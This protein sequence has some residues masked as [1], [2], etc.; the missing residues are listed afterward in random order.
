MRRS[1]KVE[2][3]VPR[4]VFVFIPCGLIVAEA[5][6][7]DASAWLMK[8]YTS[9]RNE[10]VLRSLGFQSLVSDA[11]QLLKPGPRNS[12]PLRMLPRLPWTSWPPT[13]AGLK[14]S[15]K[16]LFPNGNSGLQLR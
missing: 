10:R 5:F 7:P 4:A 16:V 11:S 6:T 14:N 12:F 13:H 9:Q 8:L 15:W 1:G 2:V 3:T